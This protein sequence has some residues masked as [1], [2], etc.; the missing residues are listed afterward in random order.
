MK[1]INVKSVLMRAAAPVLAVAAAGSVHAA[2]TGAYVPADL[3]DMFVDL[4]GRYVVAFIGQT[5]TLTSLII[6]MIVLGLI[7]G[8]VATVVSL[9][10]FALSKLALLGKMGGGAGNKGGFGRS[11]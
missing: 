10:L 1:S 5:D 8:V 9:A 2:Y 4:I 3:D 11:A 7:S 6:L